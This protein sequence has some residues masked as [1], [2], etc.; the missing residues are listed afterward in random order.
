MSDFFLVETAEVCSEQLN[1]AICVYGKAGTIKTCW[2]LWAKLWAS[3]SVIY[4]KSWR[5][6]SSSWF[7]K[8]A[9]PVT[10]FWQF[11]IF[12]PQ[13]NGIWV[14]WILKYA[15]GAHEGPWKQTHMLPW[16]EDGSCCCFFQF[17]IWLHF[18]NRKAY[19]LHLQSY[20]L[21]CF[22]IQ[23]LKS[24]FQYLLWDMLAGL[25]AHK[26]AR[27]LGKAVVCGKDFAFLPL[28]LCLNLSSPISQ[29]DHI[30]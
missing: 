4:V 6:I 30:G 12:A 16:R 11:I 2:Q 7:F 22:Y 5:T 19:A 3:C 13:Q 26:M 27:I 18:S 8:E 24:P 28:S 29:L 23:S 10:C 1:E 17:F 9:Q 21:V 20:C 15:I 14:Q 25:G